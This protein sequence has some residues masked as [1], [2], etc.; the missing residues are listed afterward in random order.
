MAD[1]LVPQA[2]LPSDPVGDDDR[3]PALQRIRQAVG[4]NVLPFEELDDRF[5][6]IYAATT[7]AELDA[8]VADLPAPA[9]PLPAPAVVPHPAPRS[10][11]VLIGDLSVGGGV[12]VDSEIRA[13]NLIGDTTID[14]SDAV[15]GPEVDVRVS[16]IIGDITVIVPDGVRAS[17][18]TTTIIGERTTILSDA[19]PGA[20]TIR[21]TG[22]CAIGEVKLYSLS[23][24][25]EGLFRRIWKRLKKSD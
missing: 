14:L 1:D 9:A 18:E 15:L 25:P 8:V 7:R 24:V 17:L 13:T 23:R 21:V 3:A 19:R 5:A 12:A 6:A 20:P 4:E 11:F 10:S 16:S 22:F 2:P